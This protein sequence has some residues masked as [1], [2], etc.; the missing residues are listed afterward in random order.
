MM[1]SRSQ[2]PFADRQLVRHLP[3]ILDLR[4]ALVKVV[5]ENELLFVAGQ[6]FQTL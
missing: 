4:M 5:V 3:V 6:Q 1:G 2:R